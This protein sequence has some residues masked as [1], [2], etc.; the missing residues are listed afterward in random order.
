LPAFGEGVRAA[1]RELAPALLGVDPCNVA[2]VGETMNR[3][4]RGQEAAK[5]A[6]DVACWDVL[7]KATG[8]P[9]ATLLGGVRQGSFPLYVAIPLGTVD[10]TV[11]AVRDQLG[12]GV[13][14]FQ[15]KLGADPREDAERVAAVVEATGDGETVIADANGGYRLQDAVVAARL[16]E[17]MP[18]TFYEQ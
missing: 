2:L 17:G 15:L 10:A 4:L 18:R 11:E 3:A 9:L 14:R 7:G 8:Q 1:L 13:H 16:L 5:S 12:E 6:V